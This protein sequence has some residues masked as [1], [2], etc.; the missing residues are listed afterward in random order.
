ML[1]ENNF[2]SIQ[3]FINEASLANATIIINASHRIFEGH[4]P[5]Q[6]V[7]P[8]VCMMQIVKDLLEKAVSKET[9]LV[10]AD[11]LKFLSVINPIDNNLAN[12]ELKYKMNGSEIDMSA[13]IA[14]SS[15]ICFKMKAQ[16]I[17]L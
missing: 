11:H 10:R 13:S 3:Y 7:V 4:F 8:G 16:F 17:V 15:A 2:Y 6:P 5:G 1:A 14:T 12:V 9:R